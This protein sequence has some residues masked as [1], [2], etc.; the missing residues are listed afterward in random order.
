[1]R[2]IEDLPLNNGG[3][4][5]ELRLGLRH[6]AVWRVQKLRRFSGRNYK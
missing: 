1:M 2:G 4:G 6:F 5:G 3:G